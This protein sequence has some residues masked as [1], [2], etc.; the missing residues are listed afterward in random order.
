MTEK[1]VLDRV[2]KHFVTEGNPKGVNESG[3][4]S[5][6]APCAIGLFLEPGLAHQLDTGFGGAIDEVFGS[7]PEVVKVFK[8]V[9]L[10]FLEDLQWTHDTMNDWSR[11]GEEL[12]VLELEWI[13]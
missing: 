10:G 7:Y 6:S 8:G 9:S 5:Y 1:E 3:K 11:F 12:D 2:R 13:H 4:C